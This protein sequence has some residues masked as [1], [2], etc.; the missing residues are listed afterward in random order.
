MPAPQDAPQD[1]PQDTTQHVRLAL[2]KADGVFL[3][4]Y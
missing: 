4:I 1:T 2:Q 3:R